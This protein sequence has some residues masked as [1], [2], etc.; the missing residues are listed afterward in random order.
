MLFLIFIAS[1]FFPL[2]AGSGDVTFNARR[3]IL[4]SISLR[5]KVAYHLHSVGYSQKT[6]RESVQ[7]LRKSRWHA[8]YKDVEG[9]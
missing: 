7:L 9:K 3:K 2:D 6:G 1:M 8:Q 5:G 4:C